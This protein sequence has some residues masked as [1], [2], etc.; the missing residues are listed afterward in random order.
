MQ[1]SNRISVPEISVITPAHNAEL[2]LADTLRSVALQSFRNFEHLV[3]DDAS[4]DDTAEILKTAAAYDS[5]IKPIFLDTN[6]GSIAARNVAIGQACGRYLAFLDADDV[7]LPGKL[8]LQISFMRDRNVAM[9]FTDYRHMSM[10]GALVGRRISGPDQVDWRTLHVSRYIGCLT[11][12]LDRRRVPDFHFPSVFPAVRAEDFLA[13]SSAIR[14]VNFA[15]RCPFDL[16][17]Y[18]L[19]KNSRSSQ[20]AGAL[21]NVWRLYRDVERIPFATALYFLFRFS[22]SSAFKHL[23]S[24]PRIPRKAVDGLA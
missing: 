9:S 15:Y 2:F 3:V 14:A 17:R 8:E 23:R 12:M 4:A 20:K 7:W 22:T 21:S 11:V 18:R 10:N 1:V 6:I 13:W 16:A 24:R 19:L 5:R